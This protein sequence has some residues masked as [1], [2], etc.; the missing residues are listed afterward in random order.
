MTLKCRDTK[1]WPVS[2]WVDHIASYPENRVLEGS[3]LFDTRKSVGCVRGGGDTGA[4][5]FLRVCDVNHVL[6]MC[7]RVA[8]FPAGALH[9]HARDGAQHIPNVIVRAGERVDLCA[10]LGRFGDVVCVDG[11]VGGGI[12]WRRF[13]LSL[14]L[15]HRLGLFLG[16]QFLR[17]SAL[18]G[19]A[20]R[21]A[22]LHC[23]GSVAS[24]L[25][26]SQWLLHR[27]RTHPQILALVSLLVAYQV[28]LRSRAHQR[29]PG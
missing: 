17:H 22:G 18:R 27:A 10:V 7:G 2:F 16:R 14:L 1:L 25:S 12:G 24:L 28:S 21:D 23:G 20:Q 4:A 15:P 11:L 5:G 26:S 8:S 3:R 9:L 6:H 13:G 29:V 19:D